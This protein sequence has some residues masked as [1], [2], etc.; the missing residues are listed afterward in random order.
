MVVARNATW[1]N[2]AC[3]T[4][5]ELLG[6]LCA[7]GWCL[8]EHQLQYHRNEAAEPHTVASNHYENR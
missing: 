8:A 6:V 7:S 5:T 1:K 4:S 2:R 3:A